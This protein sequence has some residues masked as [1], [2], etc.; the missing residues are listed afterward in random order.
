MGN[1]PATPT[2]IVLTDVGKIRK[3]LGLS[4]RELA[5]LLST[6]IR[7]VQSYEQGWRSPPPSIQQMLLLLLV[8]HRRGTS[9]PRHI[10]W[11]EQDCPKDIRTECMAYQSRQG[12]LC[13]FLTGT[14]C[15]GVETKN[16]T[17]KWKM[18]R[19]CTFMK[20]LLRPPE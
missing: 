2:R 3:E 18:C 5:R 20:E 16:W 12:Q 4:Q 6:S 17:E 10:C 19:R 13:W 8:A 9:F 15:A 11:K 14:L 1:K 7:A